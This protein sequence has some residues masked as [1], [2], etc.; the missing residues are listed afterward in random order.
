MKMLCWT[1]TSY[2]QLIIAGILFCCV[3]TGACIYHQY[4]TQKINLD[5]LS[6]SRHHSESSYDYNL[7]NNNPSPGEQDTL[8][9]SSTERP[10]TPPVAPHKIQRKYDRRRG[11]NYPLDES[12]ENITA[13]E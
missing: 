10:S 11:L 8:T 1:P 9:S 4:T 7:T 12:L 3:I 2:Y 5:L 13:V 6:R